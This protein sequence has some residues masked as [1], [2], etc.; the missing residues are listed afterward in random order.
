MPVRRRSLPFAAAVLVACAALLGLPFPSERAKAAQPQEQV[1]RGRTVFQNACARC[2]GG[3]GEGGE[4]PRLIG[5]GNG[6][7][8]Y[9][10]AQTLFNFVSTNMPV[11]DPGSLS[12]EDY[13]AVL[14]FLLDANGLLPR[15]VVLGPQTAPGVRLPP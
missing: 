6:L 5:P 15:G 12:A 4:G 2:H 14:A 13:W 1:E 3:Q 7:A 10:D 9:L 11:D 8:G